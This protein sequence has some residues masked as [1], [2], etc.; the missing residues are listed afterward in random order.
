MAGLFCQWQEGLFLQ[1]CSMNTELRNLE[2][3]L[4]EID[5]QIAKSVD[6]IFLKGSV[7]R[8]RSPKWCSMKS[9]CLAKIAEARSMPEKQDN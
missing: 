7:M 5:E 9:D 6:Y 1:D 8:G 2:K 4:V 3:K